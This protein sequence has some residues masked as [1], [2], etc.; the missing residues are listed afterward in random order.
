MLRRCRPAQLGMIAAALR[1]VF[2]AESA[3]VARSG[4]A[5]RSSAWPLAPEVAELLTLAE[6]DLL[7][8]TASR[9]P[10]GPSSAR[11]T[12]RAGQPRD[13][14][15]C[16][17]RRDLPRRLRRAP[18]HRGTPD[19]AERRVAGGSAHLCAARAS[20]DGIA[21]RPA[22]TT[23]CRPSPCPS[24]QR[25]D[26]SART[27]ANRGAAPSLT[28]PAVGATVIS[29]GFGRNSLLLPARAVTPGGAL[30]ASVPT[31]RRP[32]LAPTAPPPRSHS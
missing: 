10:T 32:G 26:V 3:A 5:R 1:E 23:G 9:L 12:R 30:G 31:P 2:N 24:P 22:K 21:R 13:R 16:R 11:R 7:A 14:P 20:C 15:P 4:R 27:A 17:R 25:A 29:D 18:A 19:R 8:S 28:S 6:A